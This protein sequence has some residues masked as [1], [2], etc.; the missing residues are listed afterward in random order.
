MPRRPATEEAREERRTALLDAAMRLWVEHPERVSNVSD[1]ARAA[2]IAK[3]T[4]YLYFKSKEDLLLAAHERHVEAFFDALLERAQQPE[5]MTLD[6]MIALTRHHIVE[7]PAFLPL[8]MLISSLLDKSVTP[9][10]VRAFEQRK[11]GRLNAAGALLCRHFDF[12]NVTA[13]VR[14]LMQSYGLMLGLWQ[15]LGSACCS[16]IYANGEA[17][18]PDYLT[19]LDN[20]LRALWR[21]TLNY[22][23]DSHA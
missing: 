5:R 20:A 18:S 9:E 14:L 19:E 23:D 4:V 7:V 8:A 11:S 21:G 6:D 10:V 17:L 2:G 15:L 12:E 16:Q 1:V 13:G 22:K 3:G